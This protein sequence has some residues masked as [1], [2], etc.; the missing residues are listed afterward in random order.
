[1]KFIENLNSNPLFTFGGY[2]GAIGGLIADFSGIPYAYLGALGFAGSLASIG[3]WQ[4]YKKHK[5]YEK[6]FL[7]I[8]VVIN[9]SNPAD[10]KNA[11]NQ[12]SNVIEREGFKDHL[13]NLEKY[14]AIDKDNLIFEYKGDIFDKEK[15]KDF[16]KILKH[17]IEKL[18][19][20]IPQGDQ[21][22]IAYI[23]PVSVSILV[24]AIFA[25]DA[26]KIFQYDKSINGYKNVADIKDRIIKENID[27]LEKFDFIEVIKENN[28][29]AVLAIDI[30]SHKINFNSSAIQSFGDIFYLKS[31]ESKGT[32]S[33]NDNWIR[34]IQEI[35]FTINKLQTNYKEIKLVYSIPI[36]IGLG[37]GMAIQNYWKILLTNYQQGEYKDLIYTDEVQYF[38]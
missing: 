23:G 37:L 10:S 29:K 26:V 11:L 28:E 22:Y 14:F 6:P 27:T 7:P 18:E 30:S 1:M 2:M 15:L 16:L 21:F 13:K 33:Y 38:L 32:I 24:G 31:K 3:I 9:I 36:S 12:L 19:R 34:Y 35:F 4:E 25:Q 20:K 8:P 5:L 17:E